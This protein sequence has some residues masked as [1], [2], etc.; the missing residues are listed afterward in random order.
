MREKD[1]FH[2]PFRRLF[3]ESGWTER[4]ALSGTPVLFF[5][6]VVSLNS[7]FFKFPFSMTSVVFSRKGIA[8]FLRHDSKPFN[9]VSKRTAS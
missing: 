5:L 4:S 3:F 6:W 2:L 7:D 1:L 8:P 9:S